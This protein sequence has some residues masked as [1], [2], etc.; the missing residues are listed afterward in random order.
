MV[1]IRIDPL[2]QH[3]I[4]GKA[5]IPQPFLQTNYLT[6]NSDLDA[7]KCADSSYCSSI[8]KF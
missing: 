8:Q 4:S 6:H 5:N 1:T 7:M 3:N 2:G